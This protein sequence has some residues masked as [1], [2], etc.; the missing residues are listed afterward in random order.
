MH[1]AVSLLDP[2]PSALRQS[3]VDGLGRRHRIDGH[4]ID[5]DGLQHFNELLQYLQLS[6]APLD[7]DQVASAARELIDGIR[8]GDAPRPRCIQQRM[9][10][11]AAINLMLDDADWETRDPAAIRA[12][13][14][15]VDYLRGG[16]DL[17]PNAMPV[18]GRLD[19][20]IVVDAAWPALETEVRQYLE[21]CRL[22]H[23]EAD[24]RGETR[25]HFGFTG[26][27]WQDAARAEME[28]IA[29][30][31]RVGHETYL[32]EGPNPHFRVA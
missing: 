14:V 25:R 15:V 20:A 12:M 2:L 13:W 1:P 17:I 29:H 24:L 4:E 27:H 19:D 26:K 8:Y 11:G 3:R 32:S 31:A 6:Q 30:C 28:W 22:R 16:V 18:I 23:V 7:S 9:R 5:R 21:F 10:R